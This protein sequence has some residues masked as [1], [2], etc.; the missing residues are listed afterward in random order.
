MKSNNKLVAYVFVPLIFALVGLGIVYVGFNKHIA[1]AKGASK[2]IFGQSIPEFSEPE[3]Q[4]ISKDAIVT[5]NYGA[6]YAYL[7]C[8][9]LNMYVPVY[10]GSGARIEQKGASQISTVLPGQKGTIVIS[11]DEKAYLWSLEN[12]RA[13]KVIEI[14]TGYGTFGYKITKVEIGNFGD[15]AYDVSQKDKELLVIKTGYPFKEKKGIQPKCGGNTCL[16]FGER[17]SGPEVTQ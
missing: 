1:F 9:D 13:G 7:S 10:Y 12:A 4:P 5:P 17:V 16:V 3:P 8:E 2:M 11:G 6:L 15:D 14:K